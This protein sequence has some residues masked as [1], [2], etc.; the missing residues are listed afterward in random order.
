[1]SVLGV[2]LLIAA[3]IT[4]I[5]GAVAG[6]FI[7][8]PLLRPLTSVAESA[9]SI[10]QGNLS[11]RLDVGEDPELRTMATAFNEMASTVEARIEREHRFTADVSHELRTPLTAMGA[12]V[13]LAKRSEMP[14]RRDYAIHMLDDQLQQF[15]RLTI[16]LL[17]IARIDS[18][19][20]TLNVSDVDVVGLVGRVLAQGRV[21]PSVLC[22][23]PS[24]RTVWRLDGTRLERV[25][26]NLVENADRYAGG[27][28]KVTLC[29][30]DGDLL[31]EVDDNGP[32][33]P[34]G[35]RHAIFGRFNRG[36][37]R[38]PVGRSKGTGLGLALVDEHV[39]MHGGEVWVTDNPS[40]GARFV[41]RVPEQQ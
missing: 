21:D 20:A 38:Q 8:R 31:I 25:L 40:R 12:A 3:S 33:V 6:W 41:V 39:R 28:T 27:V 36:S 11:H 19:V 1:L 23:Q 32:G 15:T 22:V 9:R 37:M 26:A 17:E 10:S 30:Q 5:G 24:M 35:D 16:E 4:T 18:G 34:E 2:I 13:S 14:E 29:D 7:S